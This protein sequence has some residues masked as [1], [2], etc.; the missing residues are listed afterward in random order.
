MLE[1]EK[2][3]CDIETVTFDELISK[4]NDAWSNKDKIKKKLA[5]KTTELKKSALYTCRLVKKLVKPA[6]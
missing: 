2:Y 3:V 5:F 1:Q 6:E 4:I